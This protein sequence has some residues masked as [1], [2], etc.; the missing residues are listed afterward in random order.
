MAFRKLYIPRVRKKYLDTYLRLNERVVL[1]EY[2]EK[3]D[4]EIVVAGEEKDL[5][6]LLAMTG[7]V[8]SPSIPIRRAIR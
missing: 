8:Y 6:E 2:E 5:R 3:E 7:T 1:H 4:I